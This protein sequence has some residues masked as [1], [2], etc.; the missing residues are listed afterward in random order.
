MDLYVENPQGDD[1][2]VLGVFITE[3]D[4]YETHGNK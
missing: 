3:R 1:I 2:R 4:S